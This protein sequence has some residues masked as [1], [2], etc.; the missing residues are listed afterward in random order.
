MLLTLADSAGQ[1]IF[2][3]HTHLWSVD[4][5]SNDVVVTVAAAACVC[6]LSAADIDRV[7]VTTCNETSLIIPFQRSRRGTDQRFNDLFPILATVR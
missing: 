7:A 5:C 3:I 1:N 6:A 2:Y 4:T